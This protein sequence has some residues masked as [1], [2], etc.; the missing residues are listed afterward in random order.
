M[1]KWYNE[2]ANFFFCSATNVN[3]MKILITEKLKNLAEDCGFPLYA[4]GGCV[5]DA[6]AGLKSSGDVDI[7]APVSAE[8][9]VAAAEKSG[10]KINAV[11]KNTGTVKL[12]F[13]EEQYEFASFRSDSYVR[14][15]HT[16]VNTFFTDDI[17]LDARRRDFKCNAVY[18]DIKSESLVD[19]LG[20]AE[21]ISAARITTVAD[22]EKVFGEDGLRL[23]RLARQSAQLNFTPTADCLEGAKRNARLAADVAPERI[24][25]ELNEILHADGR[26]GAQYAQYRGLKILDE[27]RVLDVILPELSEGRGMTQNEKFHL[28][29]VL[30]HSLRAVKYADPSVR[31]ASLLHDVGKPVRMRADG[32]YHGHESDSARVAADICAR[33][34]VPKKTSAEVVTLCAL[35]MYDLRCDARESKVRRFIV[36]NLA[37]FD[38]LLSVKQADYSGCRDDLSEAPAVAKFKAIYAD[39]VRENVPMT[40]AMLHVRGDEL[41]AAGVEKRNV[42]DVLHMLLHECVTK[43]ICNGR[44]ALIKRALGINASG[45]H[46]NKQTFN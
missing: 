6:L 17:L 27:T 24:Y 5:R 39:M 20:G 11:Y 38:K 7:C 15:V 26:Y 25:A 9:F 21:D 29:D 2:F 1:K 42:G 13:G 12:S 44:Q 14:G 37:V 32:N 41:I 31:L 45:I 3:Y 16:P 28:Y 34:K 22:A 33:F 36:D 40:C 8:I 19:P 43:N 10:A 18:Y 23:M 46:I 30:E 4:V 35:H